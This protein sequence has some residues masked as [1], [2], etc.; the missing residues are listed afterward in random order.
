MRVA[1]QL[2]E[3]GGG[4]AARDAEERKSGSRPGVPRRVRT[5]LT[6]CFLVWFFSRVTP[7]RSGLGSGPELEQLAFAFGGQ[8]DRK[9]LI[10]AAEIP[11]VDI[12]DGFGERAALEPRGDRP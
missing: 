5:A 3:T 7:V 1:G 6:T 4:P 12:R 9:R 10:R 2:A 11:C 8:P